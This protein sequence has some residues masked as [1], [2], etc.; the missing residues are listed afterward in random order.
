MQIAAVREHAKKIFESTA[1]VHILML[2]SMLILAFHFILGHNAVQQIHPVYFSFFRSL[3]STAILIALTAIVDRTYTYSYKQGY[4]HKFKPI[5]YLWQRI[6][7][8]KDS[9]KLAIMGILLIPGNQNLSVVG[10]MYTNAIVAGIIL[11][12][13]V[14]FTALIS[15]LCGFEKKGWLKFFGIGLAVLGSIAM[16]VIT[17]AT[18]EDES[19]SG[20]FL[21]ISFS[22]NSTIGTVII[23]I[24][25]IAFAIYLGIQKTLLVS[26]I[27]SFTVTMWAY[28]YGT[29]IMG[30]ISLCFT[31]FADLSGTDTSTWL[32]IL[33]AATVAGSIFFLIGTY[34]NKRIAPTI[35]SVYYT[36]LPIFSAGLSFLIY[37]QTISWMSSI[38]CLIIVVGIVVVAYAKYKESIVVIPP[39]KVVEL[40]AMAVVADVHIEIA[41]DVN[42]N[43]CST[44]CVAGSPSVE[45]NPEPIMPA[46][47]MEAI[48]KEQV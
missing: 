10:L 31:P 46:D 40:G 32:V 25:V 21:G 41:G 9:L 33:Y 48:P 17:G 37:G 34:A 43:E 11:P 20:S 13:S 47:F 7:N 4:E 23:L 14:V 42:V 29:V 18:T 28:L 19:T 24:G 5:Q 27:P 45:L 2:L 35:V 30:V 3:I 15:I 1:L 6:P 22:M 39:V 16:V 36:I 8:W 44:P 26:G 38:G 12:T